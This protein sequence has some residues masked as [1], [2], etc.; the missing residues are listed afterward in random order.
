MDID[1][2]IKKKISNYRLS[3][4]ANNYHISYNMDEF[5]EKRQSLSI[6]V[7][8]KRDSHMPYI[9][10]TFY[11]SELRCSVVSESLDS[12]SNKYMINY[13]LTSE[14]NINTRENHISTLP[15]KIINSTRPSSSSID[16]DINIIK[17]IFLCF[18]IMFYI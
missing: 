17:N 10:E 16:S 4:K 2:I 12:I 6:S 5:T 8:H 18:L 11:G 13:S 14:Q 15:I 7:L 3:N 9:L 1:N